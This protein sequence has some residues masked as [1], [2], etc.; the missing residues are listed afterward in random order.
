MQLNKMSYI[1]EMRYFYTL[2]N[3]IQYIIYIKKNKPFLLHF[4]SFIYF[5]FFYILNIN[6]I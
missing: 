5:L 3:I 1:D 2:V 4:Y 6:T